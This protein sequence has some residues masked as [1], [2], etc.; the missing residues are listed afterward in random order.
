MD[1]SVSSVH[2]HCPPLLLW[3]DDVEGIK[4]VLVKTQGTER[5][6]IMGPHSRAACKEEYKPWRPCYQRG[7]PY[8]VPAGS[9]TTRR[10]PDHHKKT[11]TEVVWTCLLLSGVA[12]TT[13]Q[14]RVKGGRRQGRQKKRWEDNIREWTSLEFVKG[15][16]ERRKM[17][18][19]GCEVIL[20]APTTLAVQ[21][22]VRV[23]KVIFIVQCVQ[24][25]RVSENLCLRQRSL[26]SP[27][28]RSGIRN[29]YT[30]IFLLIFWSCLLII[31][32]WE[33]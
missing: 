21:R 8:Q 23:K 19:T 26:T 33:S 2:F 16:G 9:Q 6:W 28:I 29:R 15:S 12:K 20:G 11:Q 24:W 31:G 22:T 25:L 14:G 32:I 10:P 17:E 7:S 5:L 3:K 30:S 18:E 1:S 13:L 27:I 4:I